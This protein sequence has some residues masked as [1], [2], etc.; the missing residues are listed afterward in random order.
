VDGGSDRNTAASTAENT[1]PVG[2][3]RNA[4]VSPLTQ[5]FC[6]LAAAKPPDAVLLSDL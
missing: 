1:A 5:A 3:S 4:C 2:V 6:F